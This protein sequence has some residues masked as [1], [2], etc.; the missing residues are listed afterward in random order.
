MSSRQFIDVTEEFFGSPSSFPD[1]IE[2]NKSDFSWREIDIQND[3]LID[4]MGRSRSDQAAGRDSYSLFVNDGERFKYLKID[5]DSNPYS[6]TIGI[7][8]FDDDGLLE[9]VRANRWGG[10]C[11]DISQPTQKISLEVLELGLIDLN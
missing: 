2:V 4:F 9:I 11:N 1:A 3:G 6:S 5:A 7:Y 8:D 10:S